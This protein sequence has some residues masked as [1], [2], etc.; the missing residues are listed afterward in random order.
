MSDRVQGRMREALG[1]EARDHDS[2][3]RPRV[4]PDSTAA[5][6]QMLALA[7]AEGWLVR[8]EGRAS[9]IPPDAP[10]DLV[11]TTLGLDRVVRIA[12]TDLVATVETGC[13]L[14]GLASQLADASMWLPWEP[15]GRP[16]RTVGSV[17]ATATAGPPRQGF[18]PI[19]DHVLGCTVVSGDGRVI[20]PGGAVVK[21][22]AGYDLTRIQVGGFGAFG[23]VTA[24][25]VRLRAR[26]ETDTTLVA[27][28]A[29]DA[30][31]SAGR[32]LVEAAADLIALEVL[33]PALAADADWV[34]AARLAGP[35]AGVRAE[36]DRLGRVTGGG[37]GGRLEWTRLDTEQAH[38]LWGGS[39]RGAQ[40]GPVT[41]RL[42][43]L[44]EGVD[45][46]LDLVGEHLDLG[47]VSA[48]AGSGSIRWTGDASA[49]Q[50]RGLRAA[51]ARREIPVTL[52]RAPW[53]VRKA[54]GHFGAYREGVGGL[55]DKLREVFD[56][57]GT[58]VV[59]VE[60][61]GGGDA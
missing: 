56:P 54:V 59:P 47:L 27:R 22:V 12:A 21:N 9:W 4:A 57:R 25:H 43:V 30:L 33:S 50:L 11:V 19:R 14:S 2:A 39:A 13:A 36:A 6:A 23:V 42:G 24:I 49:A 29:R 48:G 55:V 3:G 52:E 44:L 60:E 35:D 26:P 51:A 16:E 46:T 17:V 15:P 38:S 7:S 8:V 37:G 10:C 41:I 61:S 18:G 58:L 53:P 1:I 32:D 40:D 31:T 20:Q 5:M 45:E 34:L 28:G